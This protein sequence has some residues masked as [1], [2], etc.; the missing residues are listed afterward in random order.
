MQSLAGV[1]YRGY[2][3]ANGKALGKAGTAVRVWTTITGLVEKWE[4]SCDPSHGLAQY[5]G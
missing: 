2:W 1:R 4:G 3:Y 5:L